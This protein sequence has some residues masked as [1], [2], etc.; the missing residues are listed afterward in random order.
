MNY[1]IFTTY[2]PRDIQNQGPKKLVAY[3][4]GLLLL[5]GKLA[6]ILTDLI[7][8]FHVSTLHFRNCCTFGRWNF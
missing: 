1:Q 8:D 3:G 6:R 2:D 4:I 7:S 5:A